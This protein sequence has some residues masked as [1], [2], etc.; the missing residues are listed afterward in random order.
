[1][2]CHGRRKKTES[3]KG[4][5]GQQCTKSREHSE[6]QH[7]GV[8]QGGTAKNNTPE[9]CWELFYFSLQKCSVESNI[10]LFLYGKIIIF[11]EVNCD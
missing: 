4:L 1:M 11:M 5:I 7:P 2:H 9:I 6:N 3:C 8:K 10:I